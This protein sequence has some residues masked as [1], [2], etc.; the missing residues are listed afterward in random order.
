MKRSFLTLLVGVSILSGVG[1]S[2]AL[3]EPPKSLGK[4]GYWA[5][6]ATQEGENKVCYMSITAAAPEKKGS[7]TKR[8][9]VV[10]MI[11]HRPTEGSTDVISYAAGTKFK[12]SSDATFKIGGQDFNLFTQGD[13]AWARDAV[14]DH[15]IAAAL[16]KA[17]SLT[18]LGT[19]SGGAAIA[20]TVNLKGVADAYYA[21]GTACGLQVEKPKTAAKTPETPKKPV[22]PTVKTPKKQ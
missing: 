22:K 12:S 18:V 2:S 14:G 6:Y 5:A 17:Q 10:L 3:A 20:D 13:T 1:M 19:T 16:R 21:I 15:A 11:T 8:G 4:F 9:N 7:K